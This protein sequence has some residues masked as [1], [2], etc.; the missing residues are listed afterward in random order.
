MEKYSTLVNNIWEN[1][2]ANP[3]DWDQTISRQDTAGRIKSNIRLKKM[4]RSS[5]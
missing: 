1:G 3:V 5:P 4:N 2:I